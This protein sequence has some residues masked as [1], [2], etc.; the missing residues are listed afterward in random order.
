[1]AVGFESVCCGQGGETD[2][3]GTILSQK[4]EKL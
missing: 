4:Y 3:L 1:M 2:D